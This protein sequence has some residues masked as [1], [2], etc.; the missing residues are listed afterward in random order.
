[1]TPENYSFKFAREAFV[2]NRNLKL[3]HD[4]STK[5]CDNNLRLSDGPFPSTDFGQMRTIMGVFRAQ[6]L[7]PP[8]TAQLAARPAS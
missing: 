7:S 3:K 1:M 2:H 5:P 8:I 4:S 6:M